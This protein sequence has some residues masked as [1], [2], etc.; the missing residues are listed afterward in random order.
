M[1][2]VQLSNNEIN[3]AAR[4]HDHLDDLVSLKMGGDTNTRSSFEALLI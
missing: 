1:S 2:I 3:Q 4:D